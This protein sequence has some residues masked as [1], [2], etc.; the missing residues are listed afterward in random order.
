M[1]RIVIVLNHVLAGLGSDENAMLAPGGKK[2]LIGPGQTLNPYFN[3][4]DA[5]IVSTLFCGDQFYLQHK[6]KVNEKFL[7]F[8]QKNKVDAVL[9]GPAMH[10]PNYGEMCGEL[11]CFF[12]E[13]GMPV[14]LSMSEDNPA[15][16]VYKDK[17]PIVKMPRKG[18]IGLNDAYKNMAILTSQAA[19]NEINPSLK[20]EFCF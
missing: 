3:E 18:G 20:A 11:G 14:V 5:T 17:L 12:K 8:V 2:E 19:H 4:H 1:K 15:T 9:L 10:Y 13:N 16:A 6:E 7:S